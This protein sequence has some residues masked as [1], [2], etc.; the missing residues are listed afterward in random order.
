M[1]GYHRKQLLVYEARRR[2]EWRAATLPIQLDS[3]V[4][5]SAAQLAKLLQTAIEAGD[6]PRACHLVGRGAPTDLENRWGLFPLMSAVLARNASAVVALVAAGADANYA[7]KHGMTALCYA[8]KR[9]D[10]VM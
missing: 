7:N 1:Q 6:L 5:V 8:A 2:T 9:G 4:D 10:L 3:I